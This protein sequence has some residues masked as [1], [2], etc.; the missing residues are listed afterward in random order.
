M[1][2]TSRAPCIGLPSQAASHRLL[3]S[4]FNI[5]IE[6]QGHDHFLFYKGTEVC[7]MKLSSEY[8]TTSRTHLGR[9]LV[10]SFTQVRQEKGECSPGRHRLLDIV[11]DCDTG[12]G[13]SGPDLALSR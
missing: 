10:A 7:R 2:I 1:D 6:S 4:G 12:G 5:K 8:F 3:V 13:M 9:I 11:T